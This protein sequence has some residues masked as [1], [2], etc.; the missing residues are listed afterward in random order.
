[1]KRI[2]T[3]LLAACVLLMPLLAMPAAAF[4]QPV[5]NLGLTSFLDGG[6]PA[7]PGWYYTHY[8]QFYTADKLVGMAVPNPDVDVWASVSQVV[9][10][11]DQPVLFG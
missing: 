5:V 6:P 2:H 3:Y 4:D 10:Q 8:I 1:M 7:G 9:Y 11:S